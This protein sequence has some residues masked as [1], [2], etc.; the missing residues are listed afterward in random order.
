MKKV[1]GI[2]FIITCFFSCVPKNDRLELINESNDSLVVRLMFNSELPNNSGHWNRTKKRIIV[3]NN[4][5]RLTISHR[6]GGEFE[7]A[8]PDSLLNVIALKY[9]DFEKDR[10]KWDSE[11]YIDKWDSL[12]KNNKYYIKRVSLDYLNKRDWTLKYPEDFTKATN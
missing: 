5:Q 7:R 3:P 1:L 2:L 11:N 8:L 10:D 4:K 6:W 12:F 9:Y